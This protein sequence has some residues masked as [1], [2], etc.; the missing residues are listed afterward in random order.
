LSNLWQVK[1]LRSYFVAAT[2]A[3]VGDDMVSIAVV[4][5]VLDR[6][7]SAPLAGAVVGS[8]LVPTLISGPVLGAWLD[9]TRF[10]RT[11]LVLNQLALAGIMLAL[12]TTVGTAATW[13]VLTLA[14]TVGV[15]VP[16]TSGGF[17]SLLP[18][19]VP[20]G[21]LGRAHSF[22]GVSFNVA[23]IL[24]PAIAAT[25]AATFSPSVAVATIAGIALVS[26]V[27]ITGV[28]RVGGTSTGPASSLVAAIGAGLR[29]IATTP[30]LRSVTLASAVAFVGFGMLTVALPLHTAALTGTAAYGGYVFAAF[31][32]GAIVTAVAWGRWHARW[33]SERVVLVS[34]TGMGIAILSWPLATT[35][36]ALLA[37]GVLGGLASG[38]GLPAL[39]ATRQRFTPPE[40]YGQIST[41]GASLKL[42]SF[43]LGS[44]LGGVLAVAVGTGPLFVVV[45]A[46]QLVGAGLGLIAGRSDV[47]AQ[48]TGPHDVTRI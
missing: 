1:G 27:A 29:H 4:L 19:F 12:L 9:R 33:R 7:G 26:V 5:L 2:S 45:A 32:V 35:F 37:L 31:E 28:P 15:T 47:T 36:G 8:Y 42:G 41:T 30:P 21:L 40:L 17:T 43:A 18:R 6:T 46:A 11:A 3:R 22:E 16:M 10:R 48:G 39:I 20:A 38:A 14:V 25:V 24:G 23:S 13:V 44:S 34:L